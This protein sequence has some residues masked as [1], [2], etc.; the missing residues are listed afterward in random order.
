MG[1]C[2]REKSDYNGTIGK[3]QYALSLTQLRGIEK[4]IYSSIKT[5]DPAAQG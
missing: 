3:P 5:R 4:L 1:A 2:E